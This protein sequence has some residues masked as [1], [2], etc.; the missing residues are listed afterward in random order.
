MEIYINKG[1]C[2]PIKFSY[3]ENKET[4]NL[5][6]LIFQN[7]FNSLNFDNFWGWGKVHAY[8]PHTSYVTEFTDFWD[9]L[10]IISE[11]LEQQKHILRK[12][13]NW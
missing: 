4:Q 1:K 7:L 12:V 13:S 3:S 10:L 2:M 5:F 11:N 9:I 8:K 6:K